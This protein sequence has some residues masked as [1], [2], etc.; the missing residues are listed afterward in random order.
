MFDPRADA[1]SLVAFDMVSAISSH[2]SVILTLYWILGEEDLRHWG[3]AANDGGGSTGQWGTLPAV[4]WEMDQESGGEVRCRREKSDGKL[5][6]IHLSD[7]H[8]TEYFIT[9]TTVRPNP[10][11]IP[12]GQ[13]AG[14][15]GQG[16]PGRLQEADE[17]QWA[18]PG[19]QTGPSRHDRT[20]QQTGGRPTRSRNSV[21]Q[22]WDRIG[23]EEKWN[24]RYTE[25]IP[26]EE[27]SK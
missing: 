15:G 3:T 2:T 23:T 12:A 18:K 26:S 8:C 13:A 20:G 22:D 1:F 9:E 17:G 7:A 24:S 27:G 6:C 10:G 14:V 19:R 25:E 4:R 21:R 16:F 5:S 11:R